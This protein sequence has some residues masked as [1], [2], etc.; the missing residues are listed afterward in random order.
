MNHDEPKPATDAEWSDLDPAEQA[1]QLFAD[2]L[3]ERMHQGADPRLQDKLR[4]AFD[5]LEDPAPADNV[6]SFTRGFGRQLA[7]AASLIVGLGVL[8]ILIGGPGA[9][10]AEAMLERARANASS[11][12][13]RSFE[14]LREWPSL[15]AE[16]RIGLLHLGESGEYSVVIEGDHGPCRMGRRGGKHW[17]HGPMERFGGRGGERREG[18]RS[19]TVHAAADRGEPER[20]ER[21][22]G[23]GPG[24]DPRGPLTDW[25]NTNGVELPYATLEEMV[26]LFDEGYT[27]EVAS[28]RT[29]DGDVRERLIA[30]AEGEAAESFP[31][32]PDRIELQLGR[33]ETGIEEL[34]LYWSDIP[35]FGRLS[36]DFSSSGF[37]RGHKGDRDGQEHGSR[38]ERRPPWG[39]M[40]PEDMQAFLRKRH[41]ECV[42]PDGQFNLEAHWASKFEEKR[43]RLGLADSVT[44]EQFKEADRERSIVL[45]L[46]DEAPSAEVFEPVELEAAAE[47]R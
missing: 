7:A 25:L 28:V 43:K 6:L 39:S 16:K 30:V 15:N 33:A 46:L 5:R 45:R 42:G 36:S 4:S 47:A 13:L 34:R 21:P 8:L 18:E 14:I 38:S 26:G 31:P 23:R 22:G 3:L 11:G 32:R 29:A 17:K 1:R 35:R 24:G 20:G 37:G 9:S 41:P 10:S 12:G 27:L 44:Y 40:S 19:A 2:S